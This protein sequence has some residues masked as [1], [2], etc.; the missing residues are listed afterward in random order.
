MFCPSDL[1]LLVG[2]IYEVFASF[3][4]CWERV[5]PLTFPLNGVA[6]PRDLHSRCLTKMLLGPPTKSKPCYLGPS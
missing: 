6:L 2:S 5:C 1:L 4:V 3:Q